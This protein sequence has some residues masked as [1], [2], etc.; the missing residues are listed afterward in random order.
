[1]VM[2]ACFLAADS[3]SSSTAKPRI[4]LPSFQS[5]SLSKPYASA[6]PPFPPLFPSAISP[7]DMTFSLCSFLPSRSPID[8]LR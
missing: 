1:M 4:H 2:T 7:I 5:P 3:I 8:Y 6:P